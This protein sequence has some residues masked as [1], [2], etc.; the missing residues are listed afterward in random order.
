MNPY[1]R[2]GGAQ[3]LH[4]LAR[5]LQK[6]YSITIIAGNFPECRD[7]EINGVEYRFIGFSWAGPRLGQVLFHFF[8]L[9]TALREKPDVWLESFTPPWSTSFLPLFC[10]CPVIGV[11]HML[12][13]TDMK[14]KYRL[15]FD[16]LER[17]GLQCYKTCIVVSPFQV[18]V[19]K[20]IAPAMRTVLIANGV[21]TAK[22]RAIAAREKKRQFLFLGR[23]EYDQKGIDILLHAFAGLLQ[24]VPAH[25]VL[26]GTGSAQDLS[27][28]R[29]LIDSLGLNRSVKLA[30][31]VKG[32]RKTQL[33]RESAAVVMASRY[34]TYGMSALEAF[35]Q[36]TVVIA[37]D[38]EY[39][40]W[41]PCDG[42]YRFKDLDH[43]DLSRLML[44]VL[45]YPTQ[46]KKKEVAAIRFAKTHQWKTS[47]ASYRALIEEVSG[48]L[49]DKGVKTWGDKKGF[50]PAFRNTVTKNRHHL[51]LILKD[52][53]SLLFPG[54]KK[55]DLAKSMSM[56][57]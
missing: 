30:G 32:K 34:E 29:A 45:R 16:R 21:L 38:S 20:E 8:L 47:V 19:L 12:S 9:L 26:A 18:R 27:K 24:K 1:Y 36:G 49:A 25:L 3:A 46:R 10:R 15:P 37:P 22:H 4:T 41:L 48:G 44:R 50:T 43:E 5:A 40:T 33:L 14:R 2:G 42:S 7:G 11:A 13:A 23:I 51:G 56:K 39:F 17:L 54:S 28:M 53:L 55:G 35:S 6:D 57:E 31:Y 52:K